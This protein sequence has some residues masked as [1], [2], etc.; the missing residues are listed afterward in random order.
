MILYIKTSNAPYVLKDIKILESKYFVQVFD[1]K[2]NNNIKNFILNCI[3][4]TFFFIKNLKLI[5]VVFATFIDY[6]SPLVV[7]LAMV[8]RKKTCFT[9]G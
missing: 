8:F 6:Y 7:L 2:Q 4:L 3:N 1:F 5:K 9:L